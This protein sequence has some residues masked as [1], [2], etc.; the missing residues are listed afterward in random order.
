MSV[1]GPIFILR[2]METYDKPE[3]QQ[4]A[5]RQREGGERQMDG[6]SEGN[7]GERFLPVVLW[8]TREKKH[9]KLNKKTK[10]IHD[11]KC[12]NHMAACLKM[13]LVGFVQKQWEHIQFSIK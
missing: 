1:C 7:G 6:R 2:R 9:I 10:S 11:V 8:D 13:A 5:G 4:P 12:S 3:L